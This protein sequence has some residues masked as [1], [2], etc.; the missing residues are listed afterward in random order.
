MY[1]GYV[2]QFPPLSKGPNAPDR[3]PPPEEEGFKSMDSRRPEEREGAASPT[4]GHQQSFPPRSDAYL[5]PYLPMTGAN[6]NR[7]VPR[8]RPVGAPP[9]RR[10][11][12]NPAI[13]TPRSDTSIAT[14]MADVSDDSRLD[15]T[16]R[17]LQVGPDN[18]GYTDLRAHFVLIPNEINQQALAKSSPEGLSEGGLYILGIL[19]SISARK[20][21]AVRSTRKPRRYTKS[22]NDN[23]SKPHAGAV[24]AHENEPKSPSAQF[25]E[26]RNIGSPIGSS[27][28]R[29]KQKSNQQEPAARRPSTVTI[30]NQDERSYK[31]KSVP[32]TKSRHKGTNSSSTSRHAHA[33]AE[34][35]EA[36]E[37]GHKSSSSQPKESHSKAPERLNPAA[38]KPKVVENGP[39]SLKLPEMP[40]KIKL[41]YHW[42]SKITEDQ[43]VEGNQTHSGPKSRSDLEKENNEQLRDLRRTQQR[44]QLSQD[45]K[46]SIKTTMK[47]SKDSLSRPAK[48]ARPSDRP[49][50]KHPDQMPGPIPPRQSSRG[51]S[52]HL[53]ASRETV[54]EDVSSISR[55]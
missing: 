25:E 52:S 27:S 54:S 50:V 46:S 5:G 36:S 49:G 6:T 45:K 37:K 29:P 20:L 23:A 19:P 14:G 28:P 1:L 15:Q 47:G 33:E 12:R 38:E 51:F 55:N 2:K 40:S 53:A 31:T 44:Q 13:T 11:L 26:S 4:G 34:L 41:P 7:Q 3:P 17:S 10:G 42:D 22:P 16:P 39:P 18:E 48:E 21:E 32:S 9:S 24:P 8:R 30:G 35:Y 43:F